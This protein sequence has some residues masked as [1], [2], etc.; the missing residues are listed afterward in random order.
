MLGF[1]TT[2]HDAEGLH[3]GHFH[4]PELPRAAGVFVRGLRPR[5][6]TAVAEGALD[7]SPSLCAS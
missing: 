3:H 7:S 2:G 1:N 6:L 4:T 5:V